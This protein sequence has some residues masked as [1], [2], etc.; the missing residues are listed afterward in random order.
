MG[1]NP[2][3]GLKLAYFFW[4]IVCE[5]ERR[6]PTKGYG[7]SK[8]TPTAASPRRERAFVRRGRRVLNARLA[9]RRWRVGPGLWRRRDA[10]GVL[11][12]DLTKLDH[13]VGELEA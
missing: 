1:E 10:L 2:R 11:E 13:V 9:L 12:K 8:V 7:H 6:Y 4:I 5:N 3:T